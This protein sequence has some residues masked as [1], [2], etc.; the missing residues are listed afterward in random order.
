MR[1]LK[2]AFRTLFKTPFITAVAVLSIALGIGANAAIFSLFEQMLLRPLPVKEPDRLVNFWGPGPKPGA[3]ISSDAG[4]VDEIFSQPMFRDL[5]RADT[6]LSGI[7]AHKGIRANLT[8]GELT[9][10]AEALIVSGTYFP[11]LGLRPALGR[12]LGP[13]DDEVAGSHPVA[14]LS[15]TYW[16][17]NLGGDPAVLNRT[18]TVNGHPFTIVGVA[19]RGFEGTTLGNRPQVYVPLSM[20]PLVVDY[21]V[22]LNARWCHWLHLFGRLEPGVSIEQARATVNAVYRPIINEVEA[23]ERNLSEQ[24]MKLFRAKEIQL[25]QGWRGQSEMHAEIS[26]P[27]ALLFGITGVVL[28]IACANIA[29]L[30]LAR[31]A[32]RKTEIAVRLAMGARR[33]QVVGQLLTESLVLAVLGGVASLLVAEWTL[34]VVAAIA[35][36]ESMATLNLGL[37]WPMVLFAAAL[38]LGTGLLFGLF[39]ALHSTRSDLITSIRAGA[40]QIAG[41][42]SAARFRASLVTAQVALSMALLISAGLFLKSL[43]NVSR[44]DLGLRTD[45][46]ITFAVAPGRNGYSPE[47]SAAFLERMRG[48]LARQPGVT[49]ATVAITPVLE[50]ISSNMNVSVEG[51]EKGPDTDATSLKDWVGPDYFETMGMT[52]LAGRD[53]VPADGERSAKVAVVN[54]AFARKFGLGENPVGKHMALGNGP[55]DMEIVGLVRDA[56]V[57]G[58]KVPPGAFVAVP[59][60][61]IPV[62]G[63]FQVYVRTQGDPTPVM[64]VARDV[65]AGLDPKLPVRGLET[66]NQQVGENIFLDRMI[67]TLSAALAALATLLAAIGLYGVLAYT[68]TQRTREIGVRMALGANA[69]MVRRMVLGQTM[70][71]LLIGG[72]IGLVAAL[73]IGRYLASLLYGLRANDPAVIGAAIVLLAVVT[74]LAGYLPAHRASQV[75]PVTALRYE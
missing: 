67:S 34:A 21:G 68:V 57:V 43:V 35:P 58:V 51:F 55:L 38:A 73:L 71:M 1:N 46:L 5:A 6:A 27:M 66:M 12:L 26:T 40:G 37:R 54:E 15:H 32:N 69:A 19:P 29:N 56:R 3:Q 39:P 63:E 48:E 9:S 74:L 25:E 33:R 20:A 65:V 36:A 45:G 23:P 50:G 42:R 49:A 53:I 13:E 64:R 16:A 70:R 2:L 28:L 17:N 4:G 22:D 62:N 14:V 61:L 11:V 7:A 75:D 59:Y 24:A 18:I 72:V 30:L 52:L 8:Y 44:V 60:Q 31:G 47:Q 41:A 10:S